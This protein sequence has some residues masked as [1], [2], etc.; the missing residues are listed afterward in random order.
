M[1]ILLPGD[2]LLGGQ[3]SVYAD[4]DQAGLALCGEEKAILVHGHVCESGPSELYCVVLIDADRAAS[5]PTDFGSMGRNEV[6]S[7]IGKKGIS[8]V[9]APNWLLIGPSLSALRW[10]CVRQKSLPLAGS[11]EGGGGWKGDRPKGQVLTSSTACMCGGGGGG[12][13]AVTCMHARRPRRTCMSS[14]TGA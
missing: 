13:G 14:L 12:G 5:T 11:V 4:T 3:V 1:H 7:D 9:L 10:W 6:I 2:G 8:P